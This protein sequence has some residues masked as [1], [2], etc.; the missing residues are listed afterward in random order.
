M[1]VK[2][3]PYGVGASEPTTWT[4]SR[5]CQRLECREARSL[6]N[7]TLARQL[8]KSAA[9]PTMVVKA[10]QWSP[11]RTCAKFDSV[12]STKQAEVMPLA[13][14]SAAPKDYYPPRRPKRRLD[15]C[16]TLK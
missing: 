6:L 5:D 10:A 13:S 14:R 2:L 12:G 3:T 1:P 16:W 9:E 15:S 11:V 4:G 8:I 7:S